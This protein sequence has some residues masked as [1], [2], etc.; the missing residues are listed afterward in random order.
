[1][2]AFYPV[3]VPLVE[4]IASAFRGSTAKAARKARAVALKQVS[5]T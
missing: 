2:R 1:M 5:A 4:G 3:S